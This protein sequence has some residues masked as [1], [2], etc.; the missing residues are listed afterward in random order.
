MF[1]MCA[2]AAGLAWS[3][4]PGRRLVR[5]QV[6]DIP[7]ITPFVVEHRMHRRRCGCGQVS[8]AAA[9]PGVGAA[10]VYGPLCRVRHKARTCARWRCICWCSSTSP[11]LAPQR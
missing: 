3:V 2:P 7:T 10:A 4:R 6:H 8:T 1:L 9:P 5:R 11:S